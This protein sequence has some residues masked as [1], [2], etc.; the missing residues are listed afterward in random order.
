[1]HRK[2]LFFLAFLGIVLINTKMYSQRIIPVEE[3]TYVFAKGGAERN[4]LRHL[5]NPSELK[6]YRHQ[7]DDL[8]S[9][10]SYF[11][12]DLSTVEHQGEFL[13][14]VTFKLRGKEDQGDFLHKI[15]L[16]SLSG[17]S[18]SEDELSYNSLSGVGVES[19]IQGVEQNI[20]K[21]DIWLEFDITS[22]VK[23]YKNR[24][25][26]I[27]S[28]MLCDELNV[29]NQVNS[30]GSVVTFHSKDALNDYFPRLEI[31]ETELTGLL[32]SAIHLNNLPIEGFSP[33]VFHYVTDIDP[34]WTEVPSL[35]VVKINEEASVLITNAKA[36]TGT[37]EERTARIVVTYGGRSLSYFILF[38]EPVY[39]ED[40]TLSEIKVDDTHLEFFDP[41]V[42]EYD[43]YYPYS[44]EG[45]PSI[46]FKKG[47]KNQSVTYI[48]AEDVFSENKE[49]RTA[50]IRVVSGDSSKEAE[51]K[52][53]MKVLPKL[54]LYLCIGQSNM[55]G[56]GYMDENSG[57][58]IELEN[59]FLL[60]PQC[61][62]EQSANPMNKYSSIR[63]ELSLQQISPAWGF[64]KYLNDHLPEVKTGVVVNAKGG[65][66]IE[67][68]QKGQALYESTVER[69]LDALK[70]GD[71]KA[72]IWHQGES[73]TSEAKVKA[74]PHLLRE[75][76]ESFRRDLS[77]PDAWFLAGE[78]IH[79]WS[80]SERFN[81]MLREISSFVPAADWVS[82]ANL[83]PRAEGDVHF[84]RSSTIE[85]GERY[86]KKII[87]Q[88]YKNISGSSLNTDDKP[89]IEVW[90]RQVSLCNLQEDSSVFVSDLQGKCIYAELVKMKNCSFFLPQ[91][92]VYLLQILTEEDCFRKKI[93][94]K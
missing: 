10:K 77:S 76:V 63:K 30:Q 27:L 66:A 71:L 81:S 16:Y 25:V 61:R 93:I 53:H 11:K 50:V 8:W 48:P 51:Y 38:A 86:A 1:M 44:F 26:N 6:S 17:S 21:T 59:S 78:L 91:R 12:F 79:T 65:S 72:I 15:N 9:Y 74:Y 22:T 14:R 88:F 64:A 70:W 82:A 56:R 31:V 45:S 87:A 34:K 32:L 2:Q 80:N 13:E 60:T 40:V 18:W 4:N 67:E 92:G 42:Y 73:N 41:K 23:D 52:I 68:W 90:S 89:I 35:D 33:S 37:E 58:G 7:S 19:L 29:R 85:L 43:H 94:I 20:G 54:D 84:D 39:T 28:L 24:G 46:K 49:N 62:F 83:M 75:M 57:D 69:M 5:E 3:D 55:A 47:N 36:L